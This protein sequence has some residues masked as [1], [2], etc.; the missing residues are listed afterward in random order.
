[1]YLNN[2]KRRELAELE[3]DG[4]KTITIRGAENVP[5]EHLVCECVDGSGV[6][7]KLLTDDATV[8]APAPAAPSVSRSPVSRHAPASGGAKPGRRRGGRRRGRRASG[9]A[10]AHVEESLEA[11]SDRGPLEPSDERSDV[12]EPSNGNKPASDHEALED[13]LADV[14]NISPSMD[15]PSSDE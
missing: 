11:R 4:Q 8:R 15:E 13:Q 1:M 2:R 5:P 3:E 6:E 9:P 14:H 12:P 7:S 10:P